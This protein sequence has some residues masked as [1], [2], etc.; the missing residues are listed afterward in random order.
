MSSD[1]GCF[2]AAALL[3]AVWSVICAGPWTVGRM[4]TAYHD[5]LPPEVPC[6][7]DR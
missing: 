1:A 6:D 7:C 2:L 5:A 3:V 4:A